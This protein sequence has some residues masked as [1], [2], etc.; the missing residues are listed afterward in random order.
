MSGSN[1]CK[2]EYHYMLAAYWVQVNE[3]SLNYSA[4]CERF[5]AR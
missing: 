3:A 5:G 1:K 2:S 4:P